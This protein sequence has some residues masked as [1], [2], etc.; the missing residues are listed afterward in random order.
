MENET[1]QKEKKQRTLKEVFN[2]R[3]KRA[4]AYYPLMLLE[5]YV[6]SILFSGT[7]EYYV[8]DVDE[9]FFSYLGIYFLDYFY[10]VFHFLFAAPNA[11]Y[12][13]FYNAYA[14]LIIFFLS[15]ALFFVIQRGWIT[16]LS[17][18]ILGIV[19]CYASKL[20][21][22]NRMELL[23][24]QDLRLTEAAGMAKNY[25][26]LNV[27]VRFLGLLFVLALFVTIAFFTDRIVSADRKALVR[28]EKICFWGI[29]IV[30]GV[31]M[32]A[33]LFGYQ[34]R[35]DRAMLKGDVTQRLVFLSDHPSDYVVYRFLEKKST[36]YSEE[37]VAETYRETIGRL[38]EEYKENESGA[39][40][41]KDQYPNVI[42]IMNESWWHMDQ[43]DPAKMTMSKDPL[44]PVKELGDKV[45]W[46]SAGVNIFGGGTISSELE[47][48]TGWNAKYFSNSSTI[49]TDISDRK[50]HSIVEY[51]NRLGYDTHAIHPY[52]GEFYSRDKLYESL[53]FDHMT[54]DPDMKFRNTFDRY[55]NDDSLADQIIYEFENKSA[56]Q[57]FI[58]SVS[59]AAHGT[60]LEYSEPL[61]ANY[62]YTVSI[63]KKSGW[64]DDEYKAMLRQV[65]GVYEGSEAY[66][67][68]VRYFESQDEPVILIMFGDHCP[69]LSFTSLLDA[70]YLKGQVNVNWTPTVVRSGYSEKMIQDIQSLYSVP[71]V[72]WS[73][74]LDDADMDMSLSN[75]S[76]L[77]SRIIQKSALPMTK[78]AL[79][80]NY[81]ESCLSSDCLNYMMNE[82]REIVDI[83]T[84]KIDESIHIK[85][86][87]QYDQIYGED[88]CNDIWVPIRD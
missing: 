80:E 61:N 6:F 11:L 50:I 65:N 26:T 19:L 48:L 13:N 74:C 35:I 82:D 17:S 37:E 67:K 3:G 18:G 56:D 70:G 21:F 33:A 43:A 51:F 86:L 8:S 73:N 1:I 5:L 76:V 16:L 12:P 41:D 22:K 34:A 60:Y 15:L 54:F 84:E 69:G 29:R 45:K 14:I 58:F 25:L 62:P 52:Y 39:K 10:D 64:T 40:R 20:K 79:L 75:L 85:S 88:I 87:I 44:G 68:L 38:I 31:L 81:Y 28:K 30:L 71:V 77:G 66:A 55:I 47:F 27:G 32:V 72:A 42:V 59:V 24:I 78:M 49:T 4:A 46:G 23:N 9:N 36:S 2:T 57:A 63:D 53:G 7:M 83:T